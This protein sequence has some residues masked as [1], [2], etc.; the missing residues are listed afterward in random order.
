MITRQKREAVGGRVVGE[1]L[2]PRIP[3]LHS[4]RI[5]SSLSSHLSWFLSLSPLPPSCLVDVTVLQ[6]LSFL[7]YNICVVAISYQGLQAYGNMLMAF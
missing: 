6:D 5:S 4:F 7:V 2:L 1:N 3:S